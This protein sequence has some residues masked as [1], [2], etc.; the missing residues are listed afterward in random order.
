MGAVDSPNLYAFVGWGPHEG[1]DPLGQEMPKWLRDFQ[2]S[3]NSAVTR[4]SANIQREIQ[5]DLNAFQEGMSTAA[6]FTDKLVVQPGVDAIEGWIF[7]GWAVGGY[8]T[9]DDAWQHTKDVASALVGTTDYELGIADMVAGVEEGDWEQFTQGASRTGL[10]ISKTILTT[11]GVVK[12]GEWVYRRAK[13]QLF[14]MTRPPAPS[15]LPIDSSRKVHGTP[16]HDATGFN[17]AKDW[18]LAA[19][20]VEARYN[21]QTVGPNGRKYSNLTPDAQRLRIDGKVDIFEVQS[22]SQSPTFMDRKMQR[23]LDILSEDAGNVWWEAPSATERRLGLFDGAASSTN[24]EF[25]LFE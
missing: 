23:Y 18:E 24:G 17:Q 1:S 11:V 4:M 9:G 13:F 6:W 8:F 7:E 19:D 25:R 21:Q 20:T 22:P 2:T 12:G 10:G 5:P 14:R 15:R 16:M 3:L